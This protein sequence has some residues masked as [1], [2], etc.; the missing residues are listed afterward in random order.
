M[1]GLDW[2]RCAGSLELRNWRPGDRYQPSGRTGSEK[3]KTLFQEFRV[4][5]WERR[6]W[7]VIARGDSILWTRRFGVAHDFAAVR[8]AGTYWWFGKLWNRNLP[9]KRLSK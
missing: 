9:L 4:P 6:S 1:E 8:K 5:L 7:P 2:E 3:I